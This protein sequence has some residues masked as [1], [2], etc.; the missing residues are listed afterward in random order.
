MAKDWWIG[1]LFPLFQTDMQYKVLK[2]E[3]TC[4]YQIKK[5]NSMHKQIWRGWISL[6]ALCV[7][8]SP[9][10]YWAIEAFKVAGTAIIS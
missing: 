8:G 6:L 2:G 1:K 5:V 7:T 10:Y 9:E 4:H 3:Y